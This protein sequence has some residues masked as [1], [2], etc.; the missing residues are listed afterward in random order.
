MD[1]FTIGAILASAAANAGSKGAASVSQAVSDFL[2]PIRYTHGLKRAVLRAKCEASAQCLTMTIMEDYGKG[3]SFPA[4]AFLLLAGGDAGLANLR[5]LRSEYLG[6]LKRLGTLTG[7]EIDEALQAASFTDEAL[8]EMDLAAGLGLL[9]EALTQAV[10]DDYQ[11]IDKPAKYSECLD[12]QWF[13]LFQL[14]FR[15]QIATDKHVRAAYEMERDA[16]YALNFSE[17]HSQLSTLQD[18]LDAISTTLEGFDPANGQESLAVLIQ[19]QEAGYLAS[20]SDLSRQI[21]TEFAEL[22][23]KMSAGFQAVLETFHQ[24][25]TEATQTDKPSSRSYKLEPET[26]CVGR[27]L[28]IGKIRGWLLESERPVGIISANGLAGAGKTTV[29][30][31]T[32]HH[33]D[34][35]KRFGDRRAWVDCRGAPSEEALRSEISQAILLPPDADWETIQ[36]E[37][38]GTSACLVLDNFETPWRGAESKLVRARPTP[39]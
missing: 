4:K 12:R 27:D 34:V 7:E 37:L 18:K 8:A 29:L 25:P 24:E 13:D 35:A 23:E 10:K 5:F 39:S 22:D 11:T 14:S 6:L 3:R 32:M 9:R 16:Q 17:Q 30:A 26:F 1:G 21:R 15:K 31:V 36:N 28:E 33:D 38:G 2:D 19:E 20:L